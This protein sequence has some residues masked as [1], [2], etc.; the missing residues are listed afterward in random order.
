MTEPLNIHVIIGSVR[1]GRMALPIAN[2]VMEQA[3]PRDD[4]ACDLVDLQDWDLPFYWH[5]RPPAMGGYTDPLQQR[6]PRKRTR[7]PTHRETA[8]PNRCRAQ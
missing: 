8:N 3:A 6:C 5:P 1:E 2:W 7:S 4:L